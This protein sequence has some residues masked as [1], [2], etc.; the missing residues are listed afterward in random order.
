VN[1]S[2]LPGLH[3]HQIWT[4]LNHSGQFWRLS[5]EQILTFNSSKATKIFFKKNGMK[6]LQ[7][8]FQNLYE[9]IRRRIAAVLRTKS[10]QHH[11]NTEMCTVSVVF[12]LF[13]PAPICFNSQALVAYYI[14]PLA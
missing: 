14:F 4:S 13:C 9:P 6:F 2:I 11:I 12:P 10:F 5:E 1:F 8:L 7:R 3:N